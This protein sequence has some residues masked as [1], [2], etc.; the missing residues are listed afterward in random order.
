MLASAIEKNAGTE[1]GAAAAAAVAR[2][3]ASAASSTLRDLATDTATGPNPSTTGSFNPLGIF[4]QAT[5][6]PPPVEAGWAAQPHPGPSVSP[7]PGQDMGLRISIPPSSHGFGHPLEDSSLSKLAEAIQNVSWK[8][9]HDRMAGPEPSYTAVPGAEAFLPPR[10]DHQPP[11]FPSQ[12]GHV[13]MGHV[14]GFSGGPGYLPMQHG[15]QPFYSSSQMGAY[16]PGFPAFPAQDQSALPIDLQLDPSVMAISGVDHH[17]YEFLARGHRPRGRSRADSLR[18][19]SLPQAMSPSSLAA[20]QGFYSSQQMMEEKVES[21]VDESATTDAVSHAESMAPATSVGRPAPIHVP[22]EEAPLSRPM[23]GFTPTF[24]PGERVAATPVDRLHV[25]ALG[26]R[27]P[28]ND[29][30]TPRSAAVGG[31]LRRQTGRDSYPAHPPATV[32]QE[33]PHDFISFDGKPRSHMNGM[34]EIAD[35][36]KTPKPDL[37]PSVAAALAVDPEDSKSSH[38]SFVDITD[39]GN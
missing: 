24:T 23:A 16:P 30:P 6:S 33:L 18:R 19:N 4:P 2:A 13:G 17:A 36:M 11:G 10:E 8:T 3:R 20:S 37:P 28:A 38:S 34:N 12:M 31:P 32:L 39:P 21:S 15:A 1:A 26:F 25:G 35:S 29:F 27:K 5:P 7:P 22:A 9:A 14:A